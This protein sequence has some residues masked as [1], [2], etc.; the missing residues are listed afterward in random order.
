MQQLL[1]Y[2]LRLWNPRNPRRVTGWHGNAEPFWNYAINSAGRLKGWRNCGTRIGVV[3]KYF[4]RT[5]ALAT[6]LQTTVRAWRTCV[7]HAHDPDWS[8]AVV[9]Y[10]LFPWTIRFCD[11]WNK[12]AYT[13]RRVFRTY[14]RS[15][16]REVK[17]R[18]DEGKNN[19]HEGRRGRHMDRW[20]IRPGRIAE[21]LHGNYRCGVF[22]A[23]TKVS[24]RALDEYK[25]AYEG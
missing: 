22:H 12:R 15:E 16:R 17:K 3:V 18:E 1:I 13:L 14:E 10:F 25:R 23:R 20:K 6:D 2:C 9:H 19:G 4:A 8:V 11:K 24:G 21:F 5:Q 7:F